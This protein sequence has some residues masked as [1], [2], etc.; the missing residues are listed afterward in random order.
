M[1]L[2][3]SVGI[4]SWTKHGPRHLKN[5]DLWLGR[6]FAARPAA[7]A[8]LYKVRQQKYRRIPAVEALQIS[9]MPQRFEIF[10]NAIRGKY[11]GINRNAR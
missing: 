7:S 9:Q 6:R 4:S 5:N 2:A 1:A 8:A 10:A 11:S 3:I